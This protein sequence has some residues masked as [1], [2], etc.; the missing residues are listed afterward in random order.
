[1]T[2]VAFEDFQPGETRSYGD[3]EFT[4][5]EM[6]AFAQ[7]YDAQPFHLDD[8]AARHMIFGGLSASGWHTCSALMRMNVDGLL[9]QSTCLAGI[10][11]EENRWLAPVR[12]GDRLSAQTRTLEKF[13]LRSRP[14]AGIVKFATSLRNQTGEEVLAQKHSILFGRRERLVEQAPPSPLKSAQN[15]PDELARIDDPLAALPDDY[16]RARVG[17]YA[18]L[19]ETHFSADFI[20]SYAE[21]FDPLPF[22][23]DEE[24]GKAHLLGAMSAPGWQT[25]SCWMRQFIALRHKAAGGGET[26]SLASPGFS[27]LVWRKPVLVGDTLAFSTQIVAKRPTSRPGVGLV[28]NR[29]LG[30][31]QRGEIVLEFVSTVF[32]PIAS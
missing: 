1:M 27:D 9:T 25:A 23:T 2:V 31:N 10:G 20:K 29:N 5:S 8:E 21:K 4:A 7:V 16:A 32:S 17:A 14:D 26:P 13:N 15:K 24:A 30:V 6:I 3:Y 18:D 28:Q 22:H 12:P 19:G 11:V